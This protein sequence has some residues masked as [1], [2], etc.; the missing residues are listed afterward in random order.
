LNLCRFERIYSF[1]RIKEVAKQLKAHRFHDVSACIDNISSDRWVRSFLDKY[2]FNWYAIYSSVHPKLGRLLVEVEVM[3][4][5][6]DHP[7]WCNVK[8]L[9]EAN[10]DVA[11]LTFNLAD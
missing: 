1:E 7:N 6:F 4:T 3:E 11:N 2:R 5:P 10:E 8:L 9:K